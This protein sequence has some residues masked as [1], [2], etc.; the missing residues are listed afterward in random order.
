M[1][2]T[3]LQE[4][5][6]LLVSSGEMT[7]SGLMVALREKGL[8]LRHEDVEDLLALERDSLKDNCFI[9]QLIRLK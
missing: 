1:E 6:E 2:K 4:A 5:I 9:S 7:P 3:L 8:I